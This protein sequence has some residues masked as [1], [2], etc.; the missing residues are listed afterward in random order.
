MSTAVPD[1]TATEKLT[2]RQ[3]LRQ[4]IREEMTANDDVFLMGE[5]IADASGAFEVT[6]G[7]VDEFGPDRVR[8]TPISEAAIMG[9]GTG[10]AAAGKRPIVEI[11]FGDF[12][13]VC[14]EQI[15]NQTAKM[16]YMFGG[17]IDMPL[18]IR[19]TEGGGLSAASQHSGT[20]HTWFAHLPGVK[21]VAPGT[22]A[23]AKGLL[24]AAITADDPVFVFEN[25]TIYDHEG[26][27]PVSDEFTIPLGEAAVERSG[28]DVTVVA[29]QRL[30]AEALATASDLDDDIDVEVIDIRSF[31]PL[32]TETIEESVRKTGRLVIAD[33]SPL[34]YGVHAEI[35]ARMVEDEF[36]SLDTPIQ[37]VGVPDTHI[38]FSPPLENRVL[39]DADDIATAIKSI[40]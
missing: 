31:Y 35:M 18:T 19:T 40:T 4:A 17:K 12:L 24:K 1:Q 13:G 30:V 25:K 2:I 3:A 28:Q 5:D 37:R 27:V 32:D 22:P 7:L 38:P 23:A 26:E 36:F 14:A 8:D 34:S 15:M 29:S 20:P 10:A 6:E 33:E 9:A 11:M 21:A 16:R 39:P